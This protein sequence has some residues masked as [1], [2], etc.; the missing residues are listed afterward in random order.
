MDPP[1]AMLEQML[2]IG[3]CYAA[4]GLF[5]PAQEGELATPSPA[6][7]R[8]FVVLGGATVQTPTAVI[9]HT[10]D[11]DYE[12]ALGEWQVA[13]PPAAEG[14]EPA[15]RAAS[16]IERSMARIGLRYARLHSGLIQPN[17]AG[18]TVPQAVEALTAQVQA[19]ATAQTTAA[20]TQADK[21]PNDGIPFKEVISQI[22]DG[23][24]RR[25]SQQEVKACYDRYERQFGKD[26]EPPEAETPSV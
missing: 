3:H 2:T 7:L 6:L 12:G 14:Q 10:T 18:A 9:A 5:I 17:N 15:L 22:K 19:L 16:V 11:A 1:P 24:A 23:T 21:A 4:A 13:M 20:Q 8:L 26:S 25:L